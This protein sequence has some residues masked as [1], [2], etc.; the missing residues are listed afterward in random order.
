MIA[1]FG[2]IDIP[3]KNEMHCISNRRRIDDTGDWESE[4][5]CVCERKTMRDPF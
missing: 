3:G 2:T 4:C 5:L 1:L